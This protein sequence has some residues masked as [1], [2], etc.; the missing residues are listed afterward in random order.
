MTFEI[1][2]FCHSDVRA[3]TSEHLGRSAKLVDLG[4][5]HEP[6]WSGPLLAV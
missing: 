1:V 3:R 5:F 4:A 2:R 6:I